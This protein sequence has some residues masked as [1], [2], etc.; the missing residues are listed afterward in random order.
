MHR[1]GIWVVREWDGEGT[2]VWTNHF[3]GTSPRFL[4]HGAT[5]PELLPLWCCLFL[6]FCRRLSLAQNATNPTPPISLQTTTLMTHYCRTRSHA[7]TRP[8]Q[9]QL[10]PQSLQPLPSLSRSHRR[11]SRYGPSTTPRENVT[12]PAPTYPRSMAMPCIGLRASQSHSRSL[13]S[14]TSMRRAI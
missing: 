13:P 7:S 8:W 5:R 2:R 11:K 10:A 1:C 9:P 6:T 12:R 14:Y 4:Q 3:S